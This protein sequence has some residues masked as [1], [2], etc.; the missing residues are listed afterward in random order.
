MTPIATGDKN[1]VGGGDAPYHGIFNG[2]LSDAGWKIINGDWK[3]S[4]RPLVETR[5][6]GFDFATV[7]TKTA[8]KSF[9]VQVGVTH[10][11]G[12]GAGIIFNMPIQTA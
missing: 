10:V 5:V 4:N 6:E 3:F 9:S 11:E 2:K 7:Y 1:I 12:S 8:F